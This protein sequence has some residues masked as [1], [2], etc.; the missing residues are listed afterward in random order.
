MP[1]LPAANQTSPNP[2]PGR[3]QW[4]RDLHARYS[5]SLPELRKLGNLLHEAH[6]SGKPLR[7]RSPAVVSIVAGA[8]ERHRLVQRV[9]RRAA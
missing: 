2:W 4:L 1:S 3:P 9:K 7:P 5:F 8:K 6:A